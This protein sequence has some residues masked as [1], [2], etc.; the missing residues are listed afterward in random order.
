M[1]TKWIETVD[2][3]LVMS[4]QICTVDVQAYRGEVANYA[5]NCLHYSIQVLLLCA[6]NSMHYS[7]NYSQK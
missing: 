6:P 7:Q 1:A 5:H 2:G 3:T 4:I